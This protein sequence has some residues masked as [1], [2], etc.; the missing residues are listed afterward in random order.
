MKPLIPTRVAHAGHDSQ[1]FF[2][3]D[4]HRE[5]LGRVSLPQTLLLAVTGRDFDAETA[6]VLTD[7]TVAATVADPRIWPLKMSRHGAAYGNAI[8]GLSAGLSFMAEARMGPMAFGP[9]AIRLAELGVEASEV[10]VER[11][12]A[13][14]F[15]RDAFPAGF[16]VPFRTEDE[17]SEALRARLETKGRGRLPYMALH[18]R[19]VRAAADRSRAAPNFTLTGAAAILDMGV[20]AS[21]V[22][23]VALLGSLPSFLANAVE[24][25][26]IW[27]PSLHRLGPQFVRDQTPEDRVSPRASSSHH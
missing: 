8:A 9:V 13:G 11:Q 14:W 3:R 22:A 20:P 24:Q 7:F 4:V 18:D 10:E 23:Q 26:N 12:V 6:E 15:E 17:R 19:V 21:A 2:G 25:A 27:A 16:G 5:L 1:R